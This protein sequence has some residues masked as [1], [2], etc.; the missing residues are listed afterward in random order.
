MPPFPILVPP[1]EVVN[2]PLKIYPVL[3]GVGSVML[4]S[5]HFANRLTVAPCVDERFFTLCLSAY[6]LLPD[7]DEAVTA[8][9]QERLQ[10][11][12]VATVVC[13]AVE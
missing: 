4:A 3:V 8:M 11:A 12:G 10:G 2:Q 7:A 13:K 1:E 5:A 6:I 9:V